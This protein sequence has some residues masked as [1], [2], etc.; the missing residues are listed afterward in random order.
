MTFLLAGLDEV[1]RGALAG[2]LVAVATM[3]DST[4]D[5]KWTK[6]ASP[7]P[8]VDDSKKFSSREGRKEIFYRILRHSS[9][10]D[11]GVGYVTVDEINEKGIDYA[12][13]LAFWRAVKDLNPQPI[14]LLVDGDRPAPDFCY[15]NQKNRPKA[16]ALWWPVGAASIMAKVIR[17]EMMVEFGLDYL[18]YKWSVNSGYGTADHIG[19]LKSYG[20]SPLHR[21]QFIKK[22]VRTA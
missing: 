12:N 4:Q 17:D 16:D 11:F 9:L 20:P 14:F 22:I 18:H 13:R 2:P 10:V 15:S 8:G 19:A 6:D 21:A 5:A 7:I 1:G 3:F